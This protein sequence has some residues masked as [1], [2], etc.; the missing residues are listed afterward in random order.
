[1]MSLFRANSS[2]IIR[3]ILIVSTSAACE[4]RIVRIVDK[5]SPI[6]LSERLAVKTLS[7]LILFELAGPLASKLE[8]AIQTTFSLLLSS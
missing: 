1:M 5:C 3:I 4:Q 8:L 6:L 2:M 7:A